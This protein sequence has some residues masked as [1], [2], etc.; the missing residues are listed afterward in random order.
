MIKDNFIVIKNYFRIVKGN[1]FGFFKLFLTS[2]C[3]HSI[4]LAIPIIIANIVKYITLQNYDMA[5]IYSFTLAL[6]YLFYN[7]FLT[8]NYSVYTKNTKYSCEKIQKEMIKKISTYDDYFQSKISRGEL[9]STINQDVIDLTKCIDRIAEYLINFVSFIILIILVSTISISSALIIFVVCFTYLLLYN[10]CNKKI[11]K[12]TRLSRKDLDQVSN[13]F[14]QMLTGM[15]EVKVFNLTDK[16]LDKYDELKENFD[17]NYGRR[18]RPLNARDN[19]ITYLIYFAKVLIYVLCIYLISKG[20]LTLDLLILLISYYDNSLTICKGI[21]KNSSAIRM[22]S[23]SID[24]VDSIIHYHPLEIIK[25]GDEKVPDCVNMIEFQNVDFKYY[26]K[27]Q[28]TL[29]NLNFTIMPNQI[30]ALVGHTGSGKSTIGKLLLR[31]YQN[32]AGN[33]LINGTNIYDFEKMKY[34][35]LIS[36]VTQKPFI[37]EMSIMDNFKLIEQD[38][39]KIIEVCKNIGIDDFITKLQDGYATLLKEDATNLSGGQ[40][41]LLSIARTLLND[42][43]IIIFDEVTSSLDPKT[44]LHVIEILKKIKDIKTVILITHKPDVMMIADKLVVLNQGEVVGIGPHNVL[45]RDN[46]YYQSLISNSAD[47]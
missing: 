15:N 26:G 35:K 36:V 17:Y 45:I 6:A 43:K 24:R 18:R 27:K 3:G 28:N 29:H 4:S 20:K 47:N 32:N 39:N 7:G 25:F 14:S 5:Y 34:E 40:K 22:M 46:Q 10:E 16:M 30:T 8:W 23:I 9:I 12:Y 21:M 19:G 31:L 33:I 42:S 1:R 44:T 41:Q 11:V 13:T 2:V 38:E 37:F